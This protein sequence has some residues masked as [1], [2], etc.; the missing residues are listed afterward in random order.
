MAGTTREEDLMPDAASSS[1]AVNHRFANL[2][3]VRLHYVEAG[4]GP[5]VVLLH[6]FPEFWYAWKSQIAAL[7][8]TG[9]RVVAPDMRGYNLSGKP[10]GV[11]NYRIEVLAQDIANLIQ[12]CGAESAT[13]V[14]HDWGG[15][16]AWV[17]AMRHSEQVE[18][19]AILNCP[20]PE[21]FLRR[22]WT[23][24]QLRKSWYIFALQV[25]GPPG[26]V[27]QRC[28]F[29]WIKSNFR[30]DPVRPGTFTD[31]DIWRYEDAMAHPGALTASTNYYRAG[32]R[33]TPA[34]TRKVFR[35]V[36]MPVLVIWGEEERYFDPEL[37]EVDREWAPNAR[38]ER[39]PDA[40]HWVQ[41][42]RPE[43]VNALLL[44]FLRA[45]SEV[46]D[47]IGGRGPYG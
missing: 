34:Q 15:V 12:V 1:L 4:A 6:G 23:P 29:N 45:A 38:V 47:G 28:I 41:Q 40:S 33:R 18:K 19:L 13:V 42:D 43:K 44:E 30:K 2:R 10:R 32:F 37:A 24:R 17:V 20:H 9:F 27:V 31:E 11:K 26:R 16:V 36:E 22:L 8:E 39:L 7:A 46:A 5:L 25:P 3:E 35:K 21:R 14:G